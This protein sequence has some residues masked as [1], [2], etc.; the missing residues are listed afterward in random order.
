MKK[1]GKPLRERLS[2]ALCGAAWPQL[3]LGPS[4]LPGPLQA[5]PPSLFSALMESCR[6]GERWAGV[7][8]VGWVGGVE[9]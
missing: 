1:L 4:P 6:S 9:G 8:A 7:G 3:K 5:P 2:F